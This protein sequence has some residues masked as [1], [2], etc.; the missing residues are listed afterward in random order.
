M[1]QK[2]T[3]RE[4]E[5][6]GQIQTSSLK[7]RFVNSWFY[8]SDWVTGC[9]DIWSNI[10]S[11]L[12]REGFLGKMSIW[13]SGLGAAQRPSQWGWAS[14]MPWRP[15]ENKRWRREELS[16]SVCSGLDHVFRPRTGTSAA[17]PPGPPACRL[18]SMGLVSLHNCMS[19]FLTVSLSLHICK[20]SHTHIHMC[21]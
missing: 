3:F 19:H 15:E 9:P 7:K 17:S 11:R 5:I 14:P 8:V 6:S 4:V 12:I 1:S 21:V 10:F 18:Q 13:I 2:T 20:Y 16:L